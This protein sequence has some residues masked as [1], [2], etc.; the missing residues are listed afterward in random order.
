ML[1]YK[2][3]LLMA[4]GTP[5]VFIKYNQNQV[6]VSGIYMVLLQTSKFAQ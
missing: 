5:L 3:L 1:L 2:Q 4:F 6:P